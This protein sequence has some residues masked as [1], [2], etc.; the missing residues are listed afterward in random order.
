MKYTERRPS[1]AE[2]HFWTTY[3]KIMDGYKIFVELAPTITL[4]E[5][6]KLC[7]ERPNVYEKYRGYFYAVHRK[8]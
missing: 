1:I 4:E 3:K 5:F 7:I 2:E 8:E 6:E